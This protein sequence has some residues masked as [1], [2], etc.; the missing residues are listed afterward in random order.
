[1]NWSFGISFPLILATS[2]V[3]GVAAWLCWQNWRRRGG[4]AIAWLEGLR[5]LIITALVFTLMRPEIVRQIQRTETPVVQIL[6]DASASM[7]TRDLASSSN[8][9]SRAEWLAARRKESF[10]KPL[11][12]DAR[13]VVEDFAAPPSTNSTSTEGTDIATA[14]ELAAQ[15]QKDLKAVLVLSDGDA[16]LGPS[17]LGAAT[18]FRDRGVPVFTVTIGR[19]AFLPDLILETGSIPSYGLMGEQIAIP[20]KV[21]SHLDREVKTTLT[22]DDGVEKTR[23]EIT[24]PAGGVVQDAVAWYP[25]RVG[26]YS[27]KLG[28]PVEK[29]EALPDNNLQEARISVRSETIK[30]LVVDSLPRWEYRYLRNALERDPG[31]D[32]RCLLFHP[33]MGTGSGRNYLPAFPGSK[34]MLSTYDVVFLGDV[35]IGNGELKPED[36]ELLR[37]LVEQQSSGLI[38]LPGSRGR[39]LT[40]LN[41]PLKELI[42]VE[43]DTAKPEGVGLQNESA[44]MLSTVGKGHLLTRFDAD[45]ERNAGIWKNL[46]GF[47]WSA[48]IEKSRP[49][50]EVLAVHSSLRN[51]WGRIPL[52]VTRN[53]GSGKVL[54]MGTD[55]AW[56]W[57]RGVEDKYHYRFWSQVVRWMAH[58]R[59]LA[60]KQGVR[61]TFSPEV[62]KLGD[63]VF[64]QA[65]VLD[66]SGFPVE[67][68][69]VTGTIKAPSGRVERLDFTSLEGGWG[70]FKS[71]FNPS[72]AGNYTVHIESKQ[73]GRELDTKLNVSRPVVERTGQPAQMRTMREIASISQGAS[74]GIADLDRLIKEMSLLPEPKPLEQRIRIWADPLWAG[75]ILTLLTAYWVARKLAGLV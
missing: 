21:Q 65:T 43:L 63:Q 62:P 67:R 30:V 6:L 71:R 26:E 37:G 68:G 73:H 14:L 27:L 57:R 13:V 60:E 40:L 42:P 34:E 19:D 29:D 44:L 1:M 22:I 54:F 33:G 10:W 23:K 4:R 75:F 28:I 61:L 53:A 52:L 17:P 16:N 47:Y 5:L 3:W 36:A 45:E 2:T 9:M 38:F 24:V 56:R 48:A 72:E 74:G 25:S 15:R 58:Q 32:M 20:F 8:V 12:R 55:S 46:P 35:G 70:V 51:T 50:S 31:V 39:E 49:G 69:P 7:T 18:R 11:E 41:S 59:H 66:A 64:L